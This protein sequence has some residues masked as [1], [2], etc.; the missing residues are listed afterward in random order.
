VLTGG[1]FQ[2]HV[3]TGSD[4]RDP[5]IAQQGRAGRGYC[6]AGLPGPWPRP[7]HRP[8]DPGVP[9]NRREARARGS[10]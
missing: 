9:T 8:D 2:Q 3:Q 5:N 7:R 10:Y 1:Q 6:F 4:A